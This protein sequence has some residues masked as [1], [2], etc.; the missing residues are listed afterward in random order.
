MKEFEKIAQE[1][2]ESFGEVIP[3]FK[4]GI[5]ENKEFVSKY[6]YDFVFVTLKGKI[7]IE[8]PV[9]G[10]ACGFTIDK[11]TKEIEMLSFG[12]LGILEQHE[13]ELNEVYLK[14]TEIKNDSKSFNWLK[15]K[16]NLTSRELLTIKNVLTA[17]E[18]ERDRV[19]EEIEEIIK[20][21]R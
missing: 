2:I 12:D 18:F 17:T 11:R 7:P 19:L 3:G 5:G 16:Y 14:L 6:Y 15:C 9:A 13:N 1:Y 20:T 4:Y 10:G 21:N 8:P